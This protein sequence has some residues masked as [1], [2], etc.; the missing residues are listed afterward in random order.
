MRRI[1]SVFFEIFT[2]SNQGYEILWELEKDMNKTFIDI[3]MGNV[4]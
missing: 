1:L 3:V 4:Q 2:K